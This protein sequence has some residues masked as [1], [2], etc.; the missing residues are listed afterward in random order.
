MPPE[1]LQ[2]AVPTIIDIKGM[3]NLDDAILEEI[4]LGSEIE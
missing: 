4:P 1:K 3:F 2:G